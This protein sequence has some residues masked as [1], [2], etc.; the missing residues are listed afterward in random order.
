[1]QPIA[2]LARTLSF[3]AIAA[4]LAAAGI[5][6]YAIGYL[7]EA[8]RSAADQ[9]AMPAQAIRAI[10]AL[11]TELGYGGFLAAQRKLRD[12]PA[13][14]QTMAAHFAKAQSALSKLIDLPPGT[15][16]EI[17]AVVREYGAALQSAEAGYP[18]VA[19]DGPYASLRAEAE[20]VKQAALS[21]RLDAI[22]RMTAAAQWAVL[23]ALGLLALGFLVLSWLFAGR[24]A[25]PLKQLRA[26]LTAMGRDPAAGP[27][28]GTDRKDEFGALARAAE[29]L[30]RALI[31]TPVLPNVTGGQTLRVKLDGPSGALFD[32]LVQDIAQAAAQIDAGGAAGREQL[33][34][35]ASRL[36]ATAAEI[37]GFSAGARA[38]LRAALEPLQGAAQE[39]RANQAAVTQFSQTA[40][41]TI[42]GAMASV[43][44]L[45]ER[46]GASASQLSASAE[47]SARRLASAAKDMEGRSKEAELRLGLALDQA[48]Q[49]ARAQAQESAAL[50]TA[51]AQ[52]LDDIRQ[53]RSGLEAAHGSGGSDLNPVLAAVQEL[54]SLL[55]Q[56]AAATGDTGGDSPERT[57]MPAF[58]PRLAA[59]PARMPIAAADM[60]ARLGSI[61]AEVRAAAGHD[62]TGIRGA[63]E[64]LADALTAPGADTDWA[65]FAATLEAEA[66]QLDPSLA[67][68]RESA[69]K[70]ADG[71][72][73][74]ATARPSGRA[75]LAQQVSLL[76]ADIA[77][78]DAIA[79]MPALTL[80]P[81]SA[82]D[83]LDAA[84]QDIQ[85]IGDL[86]AEVEA[87]A[88]TLANTAAL[89]LPEGQDGIIAADA[90]RADAR[91]SEAVV[92]VMEAIE[93]LNNIAQALSRA[94]DFQAQRKAGE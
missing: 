30:R 72:R 93:R 27:V 63:A 71:L 75:A 68:V 48:G 46:L 33:N 79:P 53:A 78:A 9:G 82:A 6:A 19:L 23:T 86:I 49:Q 74:G 18:S 45:T 13:A 47:E 85:R 7:D 21:A 77:E 83:A 34:A 43:S 69:Q 2:T 42:S 58:K 87:R 22:T 91:A 57:L 26:S 39:A 36:A 94:G 11:E 40:G 29:R 62:L 10:D 38:E 80:T 52:A 14:A 64:D 51:L 54:Q 56:K 24:V 92:A 67:P 59:T 32:K 55:V 15:M 37:S 61:A 76:L 44:A 3:A 4:I 17:R 8:R 60:L 65:S 1:L 5:A 89:S 84:A 35:A 90:A 81:V 28:W 12:D 66:A 20:R 88:E 16:Q 25:D 50:K 70:A 73:S 41:D 31:E